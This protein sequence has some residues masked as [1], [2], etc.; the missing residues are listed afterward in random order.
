MS[1]TFN[2]IAAALI[3][4]LAVGLYKAKT[5]AD[6]ARA[7][8]STLEAQVEQARA[9]VKSLSAE[10]AYLENPDRIEKLANRQLGLKQA[11]LG[12]HRPLSDLD[13]A[14]PPP[15]PAKAGA[16]GAP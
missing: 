12:Q 16:K 3:V 2:I 11:A 5:E 10:S 15:S 4:L 8:V 1:K 9:Q 14:L 7:R 13:A 6:I